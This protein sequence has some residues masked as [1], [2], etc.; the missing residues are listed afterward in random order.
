[1]TR[2]GQSTG[3]RSAVAC[4]SCGRRAGALC[5]RPSGHK[6]ADFH[7]RRKA[8]EVTFSGNLNRFAPEL[9][10]GARLTLSGVSSK[11]DGQWQ[12]SRV[13]HML[14]NGLLTSVEAKRGGAE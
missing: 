10:A 14:A 12:I 11:V 8:G 7:A 13:T 5:R 2:A 6:A 3:T 9:V 1:M 4:P